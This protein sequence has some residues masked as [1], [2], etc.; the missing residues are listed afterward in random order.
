M[1]LKILNGN[2]MRQNIYVYSCEATNEGVIIDPGHN[3]EE[4]KKYVKENEIK[5]TKILLTHG[6]YDHLLHAREAADFYNASL[7]CHKNEKEM[8]I[9]PSIN[10]SNRVFRTPVSFFPDMLLE[11]GDE[12]RVGK[13]MLKVL[14]TPGHTPGCICFYDEA[15]SKIF[16]GDTLFLESIGRTDFP[17]SST[18]AIIKNIKE[19]LF[20]LPEC[21]EAYPGHGEK[22]SIGHEIKHNEIVKE[23]CL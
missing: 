19:K 5:I 4:T 1:V 18:E 6:H 13:G 8:L 2:E 12:V 23:L 21:V 22:T 9:D 15:S 3:F 16:T 14:H 20:T 10:F 11:E 17:K 7:C